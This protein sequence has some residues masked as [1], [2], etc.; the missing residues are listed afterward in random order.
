[1]EDQLVSFALNA[2][3]TGGVV[4]LAVFAFLKFWGEKYLDGYLKEKGKNLATKED[5][6]ELRDQQRVL[7]LDTEEIKSQL[8]EE[9]WSRRRLRDERK[10][11]YV[12]FLQALERYRFPVEELHALHISDESDEREKENL[13]REAA[14]KSMAAIREVER[15]QYEIEIVG[16]QDFRIRAERLFGSLRGDHTYEAVK[17]NMAV[18]VAATRELIELGRSEMLGSSSGSVSVGSAEETGPPD[19]R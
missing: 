13:L 5:F 2:L 16:G 6:R 11:V 12:N 8:S 19:T 10:A 15:L 17:S 14:K 1:M 3:G 4:V 18:C 7:T 9:A